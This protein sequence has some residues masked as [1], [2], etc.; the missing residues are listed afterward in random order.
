MDPLALVF[1]KT[2]PNDLADVSEIKP[3]E[4]L[5]SCATDQI[6]IDQVKCLETEVKE[7]QE[8]VAGLQHK[9]EKD[10]A[11][12]EILKASEGA[13]TARSVESE[14]KLLEAE[15]TILA[16]VS[17]EARLLDE[18]EAGLNRERELEHRLQILQGIRDPMHVPTVSSK[19]R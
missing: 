13:A 6:L 14:S 16:C 15:R 17:E 7:L 9:A 10:E 11:Q 5:K 3:M 1:K 12:I 18:I 19:S 4:A 2:V 8:H